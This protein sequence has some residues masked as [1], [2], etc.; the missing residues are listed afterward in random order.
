MGRKKIEDG[1]KNA[2]ARYQS[3]NVQQFKMGLN[4][5]TDSDVIAKLETVENKQ[6][7][8]KELIRQDIAN[9]TTNIDQ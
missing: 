3:K 6:G 8:I 5:N 7:Y 1:F 9:S 2:V 4:R